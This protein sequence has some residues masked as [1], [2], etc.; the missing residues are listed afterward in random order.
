MLGLLASKQTVANDCVF[1]DADQA[2]GLTD[3]A[4][5]GQVMQD[6]KDLMFGQA[7]IEEW[8]AFAFG[9]AVLAG[10]AVEQASLLRSIVSADSKVAVAA[11]AE[12]RA[13]RVKATENAEVVHGGSVRVSVL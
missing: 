1:I 8:G 9:E 13:V 6:G 4:A 5:L 10:A 7:G 3:A 2:G 11:F 12:V